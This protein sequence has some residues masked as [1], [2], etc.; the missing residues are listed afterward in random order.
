MAKDQSKSR[1]RV[2]RVLL[3]AALTMGLGACA[4]DSDESL[5]QSADIVFDNLGI[6]KGK[7]STVKVGDEIVFSVLNKDTRP[8]TF[9][10]PQIF[11]DEDNFI[12][13]VVEP[14]ERI[15]VKI[16]ITEKPRDGFYSFYSKEFQVDGYFG[17]LNVEE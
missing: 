1:R 17:R 14:G 13:E 5:G 2:G 3:A 9:V 8:H 10:L 15:D 11:V 4:D 7:E 12:E 16:K 6:A